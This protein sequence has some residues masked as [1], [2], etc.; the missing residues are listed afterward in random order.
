MHNIALLWNVEKEQAEY[1][2]RN[3]MCNLKRKKS[4]NKYTIN[5]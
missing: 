3:R 2:S 1:N 4:C 5:I